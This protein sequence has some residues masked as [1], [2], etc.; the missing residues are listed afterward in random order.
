M[1]AGSGCGTPTGCRFSPLRT[2]SSRHVLSS[3]SVASTTRTIRSSRRS[4]GLAV[5]GLA[6]E[7]G[8]RAH[9][10]DGALDLLRALRPARLLLA[11]RGLRE[12]GPGGEPR[13]PRPA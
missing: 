5:A 6:D 4:P 2:L 9:Q 8:Q 3:A 1:P 7:A 12:P 11:A 13:P 10:V